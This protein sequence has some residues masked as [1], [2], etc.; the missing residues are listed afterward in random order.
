MFLIALVIQMFGGPSTARTRDRRARACSG[1]WARR[2]SSAWRDGGGRRDRLR[3]RPPR[4]RDLRGAPGFGASAPLRL[5]SLF[6]RARRHLHPANNSGLAT[7]SNDLL[8]GSTTVLLSFITAG[9]VI[10]FIARHAEH[11]PVFDRLILRDTPPRKPTARYIER[12]PR[13]RRVGHADRR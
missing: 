2:S 13:R 12:P 8:W 3:P 5:I 11:I 9:V 6:V 4:D 10:F 1:S 7:S